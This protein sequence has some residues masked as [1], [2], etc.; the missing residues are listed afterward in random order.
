M[1]WPKV[2]DGI[3][4]LSEQERW[5]RSMD[6]SLLGSVTPP[7]QNLDAGLHTGI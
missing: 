3:I 2:Q 7:K 4:P 1:A 6:P 5:T